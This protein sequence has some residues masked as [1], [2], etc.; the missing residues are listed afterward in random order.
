LRV[1]G[2][3]RIPADDAQPA[4]RA[5]RRLVEALLVAQLVDELLPE[6]ITSGLPIMSSQ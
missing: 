6:T 3:E 2:E 5:A 1:R 4:Q